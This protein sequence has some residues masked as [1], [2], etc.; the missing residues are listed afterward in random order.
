MTR[1]GLTSAVLFTLVALSFP[2][3]GFADELAGAV[4]LG[5]QA[6]SGAKVT[7]WRTAGKA[8]P[9]VLAETSAD[10]RG[11]FK[12]TFPSGQPGSVLY[13]TTRSGQVSWSM[14]MATTPQLQ[15]RSLPFQ[16]MLASVYLWS[17]WVGPSDR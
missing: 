2:S 17:P 15:P 1:T 13:L 8:A 5:G 6:V 12:L 10:E 14:S 4:R 9:S 16:A 3:C 11:A 7:L